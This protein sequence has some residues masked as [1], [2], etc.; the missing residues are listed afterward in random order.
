MG[1]YQAHDETSVAMSDT[2]RKL[3]R[4]QLPETMGGKRVLDIGC[5]EG[6]FCGLA[7]ERGATDV[8][9]IDF[10]ASNIAFAKQRYGREGIRF[11][12]Q[13][14]AKLPEGPFDLVMWTS[15]MHYELDPRSIVNAIGSRLAPDGLFVL[16]CGVIMSPPGKY[17]APV[18]RIADTRWY[19]SRDF[20]VNEI[21][22]GFSVR[23]VAEPQIT[24]GDVVPRAVF[25]CRKAL[26]VVLL[27]RGA[28][29]AG[30]TTLAERLRASATKLVNLDVLISQ[31][32]NNRHPHDPFEKFLVDNYDPANLG[33]IY[34]GIDQVNLSK[35]FADWLVRAVA[36]TDEVVILEGYLS[37]K[38]SSLIE[39]TL[40][41]RAV[42][43][44]LR[45]VPTGGYAA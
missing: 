37:D 1:T 26:P 7:N 15:A 14:W 42:V 41:G 27:V 20:L 33:K 18:P 2:K 45:R 6:Y 5:N 24:S 35:Q 28:S 19:P 11:L 30:K 17:F 21:L 22:V 16:E 25:H 43:W 23:Q 29:G 36:G 13:S 44:D 9:G 3:D 31:M 38:Q 34:D 39:Q 40:R 12:E 10:V 8:T 4:L 32:G